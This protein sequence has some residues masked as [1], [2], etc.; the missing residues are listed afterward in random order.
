M[1]TPAHLL[2]G[3]AAFGD[4]GRRFTTVAALI[5]A[6]APDLSLYMMAGVS[7]VILQIPPQVVFDQL[8]FSD[9]WQ[10]VFAI[11][12]SIIFWGIGLG[13]GLWLRVPWVVAFTGAALLHLLTDFAL[14]HD[15]ARQHFW[16]VSSWVF[17]SPLSYWDSRHGARWVAPLEGG[18]CLLVLVVLWRRYKHWR[19]RAFFIAL[20][21]LE[22]IT[23]V[24]FL[25]M[26]V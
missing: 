19:W 14:H 22:A 17:E 26:A 3:S 12:N 6:L 8:Y 23:T 7:L 2:L 15:D 24:P 5:G 20:M 25:L 4:P 13:F 21:G 10:Q 9:A 18:M 1:N 11:D 16:P